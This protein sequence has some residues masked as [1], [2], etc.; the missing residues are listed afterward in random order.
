[1][2]IQAGVPGPLTGVNN[3]STAGRYVG[4]AKVTATG[5]TVIAIVNFNGPATGD[6]FFTYDGFGQ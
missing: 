1:V 3:W 5:G 4:S 2:L 6:T